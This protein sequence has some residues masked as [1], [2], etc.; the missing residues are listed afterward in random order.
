MEDSQDEYRIIE[1]ERERIP[2]APRCSVV[3]ISCG[4]IPKPPEHAEVEDEESVGRGDPYTSGRLDAVYRDAMSVLESMFEIDL[5][6]SE[7]QAVMMRIRSEMAHYR[8]LID[9]YSAEDDE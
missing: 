2:V 6:D 4:F 7:Q 9:R 5:Q 8:V 1:D 3:K